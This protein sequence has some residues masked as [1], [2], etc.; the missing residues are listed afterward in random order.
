MKWAL[1][2]AGTMLVLLLLWHAKNKYDMNRLHK[3]AIA[4]AAQVG[5]VP[6]TFPYSDELNEFCYQAALNGYTPDNCIGL[7]DYARMYATSLLITPKV[8]TLFQVQSRL[9][10]LF[11]HILAILLQ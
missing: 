9:I 1:Y 4:S 8:L 7:Y 6:G 2:G 5:I 3:E 10:P 11:G